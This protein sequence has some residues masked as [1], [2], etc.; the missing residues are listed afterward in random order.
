[1]YT[2]TVTV[3]KDL[4]NNQQ[5]ITTKPLAFWQEALLYCITL[6]YG[7]FCTLDDM[8]LIYGIK[9]VKVSAPAPYT[10]DEVRIFFGIF[11]RVKQSV[12]VDRVYLYLMSAS[13]YK[14]FYKRGDLFF[15]LLV[16]ENGIVYLYGK[17][18]AVAYP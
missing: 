17:R 13:V 10:N 11:L 5:A 1:M 6:S 18:A 3:T 16:A 7:K 15:A 14:S 8:I 2:P 4:S 9:L 12:A